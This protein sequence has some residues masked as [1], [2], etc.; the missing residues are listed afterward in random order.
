MKIDGL[1]WMDWL[2]KSRRESEERRRKQGISGVEWLR[3]M[4]VHARD[5]RKEIDALAAPVA[6]DK[7]AEH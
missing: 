3:Q 5:I 2:H 6:H 4:E 7:P 1:D